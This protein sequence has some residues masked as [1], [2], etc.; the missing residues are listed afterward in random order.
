MVNQKKEQMNHQSEEI[1]HRNYRQQW[2]Q[3]TWQIPVHHK[4]NNLY[5]LLQSVKTFD[6]IGVSISLYSFSYVP[7]DILQ[8][9]LMACFSWLRFCS[10]FQLLLCCLAQLPMLSLSESAT[11]THHCCHPVRRLQ[12]L[13]QMYLELD[14]HANNLL[15]FQCFDN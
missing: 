11:C 3:R 4:D 6:W 15:Y 2:K 5:V 7:T 12:Y 13:V 9:L 14:G 8:Y 1:N 10:G